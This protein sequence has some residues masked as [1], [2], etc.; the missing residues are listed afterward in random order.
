[1]F[2]SLAIFTCRK[3][4]SDAEGGADDLSLKN[5]Q[6]VFRDSSIVEFEE[7]VSFAQM[8]KDVESDTDADV[9]MYA[10]A[11]ITFDKRSV[12][13]LLNSVCKQD[14]SELHGYFLMLGGLSGGSVCYLFRRGMFLDILPDVIAHDVATLAEY[15]LARS[16]P[17][18]DASLVLSTQPSSQNSARELTPLPASHTILRDGRVVSKKLSN[19][20]SLT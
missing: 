2:Y 4:S 5:W 9:L 18:I 8:V 15:C 20:C 11:D 12:W 13:D 1:M 10:D 17:V 7:E 3:D 14:P 6:D 19:M 16:I